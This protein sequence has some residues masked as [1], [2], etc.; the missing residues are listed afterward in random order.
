MAK[1]SSSQPWLWHR[2]F[3]HLNFDTINFLSKNDIVIGLPILKF[4]KDHLCSS[5]ETPEVLIDF[6]RLVQRELQAQVKTVQTDKG[7]KFLNKTLHAY[8]AIEDHVN[9]DPVPQ[10]PTTALEQGSL[11]PGPQS[12]ENVPQAAETVTM[13]NQVDLLFSLMFDEL[14]NGTTTVV[15]KSSAVTV[16]ALNQH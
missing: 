1:A 4:V 12:Q 14:L 13:S 5:Y 2:R 7:T 8:F 11:G 10:C 15:S 9:S 3:S 16:D 6:L